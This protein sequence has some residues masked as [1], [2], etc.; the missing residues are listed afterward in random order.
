MSHEHLIVVHWEDVLAHCPGR[1]RPDD[2]ARACATVAGIAP[3]SAVVRVHRYE[4]GVDRTTTRTRRA[5][6]LDARNIRSWATSRTR[7][8]RETFDAS[9]LV[10]LRK[11][12]LDPN[13][14]KLVGKGLDAVVGLEAAAGLL[15]GQDVTLVARSP[16]LVA[17]CRRVDEGQFRSGSL[18]VAWWTTTTLGGDRVATLLLAT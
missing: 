17:L 3:Q 6:E 15:A 1:I 7:E 16:D 13:R 14:E 11:G 8:L 5:S 2:V 9:S 10:L 12:Y 18:R 4:P